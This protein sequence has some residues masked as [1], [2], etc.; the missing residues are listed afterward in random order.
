MTTAQE[1]LALAKSLGLD[2]QVKK[3]KN[4]IKRNVVEKIMDGETSRKVSEK[5]LEDL[6]GVTSHNAKIDRIDFIAGTITT[7]FFVLQAAFYTVMSVTH[8]EPM[9]ILGIFG[10]IFLTGGVHFLSSY[11][12][13]KVQ[14]LPYTERVHL[15]YSNLKETQVELPYGALLKIKEVT[16]KNLFESIRVCYPEKIHKVLDPAIVGVIEE[17]LYLIYAWDMNK[18]IEKL[19]FSK[20]SESIEPGVSATT[21]WRSS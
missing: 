2:I 3:T 11:I 5:D 4:L 12:L 16:D 20:E 15:H 21:R 14:K 10:L 8:K 1:K 7:I 18:D 19:Q 17:D 13:E 9:W 6:L